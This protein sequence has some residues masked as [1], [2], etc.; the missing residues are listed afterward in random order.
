LPSGL[1]SPHLR[2][3]RERLAHD[4]VLA[5]HPPAQSAL[6]LSPESEFVQVVRLLLRG[7]ESLF[8]ERLVLKALEAIVEVEDV[9][10]SGVAAG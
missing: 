2:L 8:V 7:D 6:D 9:G 3:L 4:S 1:V 5:S 10:D